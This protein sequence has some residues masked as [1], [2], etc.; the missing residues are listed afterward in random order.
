MK[1]SFV[2]VT[3]IFA[4]TIVSAQNGFSGPGLYEIMNLKSSR[5]MALD[6]KDRTSVIQ[7]VS[8]SQEEQRWIVEPIP[9]GV[10]LIRSAVNGHALQLTDNAR[11]KPVVCAR[12]NGDQTQHWRIE[13]GKDGN[14]L[15]VSVAGGR[16]LDIPNGSNQEGLHIQIYDR[17]GDSNQRFVFHRVDERP[18]VDRQR[19]ERWDR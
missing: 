7:I 12:V 1:L 16:V 19:R 5:M 17:D 11:S 2:T 18:E 6:M 3:G 4:A 10:F 14:P 15:I 8:H 13:P 9:G